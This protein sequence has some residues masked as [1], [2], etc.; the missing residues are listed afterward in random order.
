MSGYRLATLGCPAC[1]AP[2][3]AEGEDEV[4]YC[5][6]C[7][8]GYVFDARADRLQ[9]IEVGFVLAPERAVSRYLP[10]WALPARARVLERSGA[11]LD[12]GPAILGGAG[13]GTFVVPA[14]ATPIE[15]AT[16]LAARYTAE[17]PK[18]GERLGERLT[19]G[20]FSSADAAKLAEFALV[21]AEAKRGGTL[22]TLRYE[23]QFGPAR[24]LG[25]PFVGE[26]G[27]YADAHFHLLA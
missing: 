9:P 12:D 24:L 17:F 2:L 26:P 14:Y 8:N 16:A 13:E 20:R 1:G 27:S 11:A 5:T 3:A 7:R 4:F 25:V 6:A 23:L 10:F 18:L 21:A 22:T 19:G 15:R